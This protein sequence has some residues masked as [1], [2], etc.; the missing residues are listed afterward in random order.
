MEE[1]GIAHTTPVFTYPLG[2]STLGVMD[3]AGNV[4]EWQAKFH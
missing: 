4:W 2:K 3:M 1:S